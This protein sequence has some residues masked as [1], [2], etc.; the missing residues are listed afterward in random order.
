MA[1]GPLPAG[2]YDVRER[3]LVDTCRGTRSIPPRVTVLKRH[4]A[5]VPHLNVPIQQ[6]GDFDK[7]K[8][9]VDF[10]ARG[11]QSSAMSHPKNCPG[12]QNTV[13]Q[14]VMNVTDQSFEVKTDFEV[15]DGWDCPNPRP[16]PM[17]VTSVV[18]EYRLVSAACE[19]RCDGT[20]PGVQD[21][22][23]P[24]GPVAL[25]CACP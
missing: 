4:V 21:S 2:V 1:N 14:V 23:V 8:K 7:P 9:R 16:E 5:G 13:Q 22:D 19:A 20:V 10:D 11:F 3:V 15:K 18:Y 12:L 17:C 25:A 6:F 24:D